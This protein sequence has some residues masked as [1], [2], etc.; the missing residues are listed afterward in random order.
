MLDV[1][2]HRNDLANVPE[3]E[4]SRPQRIASLC[5]DSTRER[6]VDGHDEGIGS[7]VARIEITSLDDPDADRPEIPRAHDSPGRVVGD[8][9][10]LPTLGIASHPMLGRSPIGT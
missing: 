9:V 4:E 6:F 8:R 5:S 3:H 7:D 2:H 1:P 10:V